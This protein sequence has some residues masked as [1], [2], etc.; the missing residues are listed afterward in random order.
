MRQRNTLIATGLVLLGIIF[1]LGPLFDLE[2]LGLALLVLLPGLALT[3]IAITNRATQAS[4][5]APGAVVTAAGLVLLLTTLLGRQA[6][7]AYGWTVL[8]IGA[9]VG[10]YLHGT[11]S[12]SSTLQK[13]GQRNA[14]LGAALL[15]VFALTYELLIFGAY[16]TTLRWLVP[17]LLIIGGGA[18]LYVTLSKR[19]APAPSTSDTLTVT[20]NRDITHEDDTAHP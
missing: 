3:A 1:L 15:A 16:S 19:A 20:G 11:Y 2:S 14:I 5:V 9:G 4:L 13:V 8:V 6:I 7:W 10:T 18:L 17:S 12:G